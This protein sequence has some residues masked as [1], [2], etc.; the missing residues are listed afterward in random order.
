[1]LAIIQTQRLSNQ[2]YQRPEKQEGKFELP[3]LRS[4]ARL[5]LFASSTLTID[6][7]LVQTQMIIRDRQVTTTSLRY[8][9]MA[10]QTV[11]SMKN[12]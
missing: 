1:M 3:N 9:L 5:L 8:R 2:T 6:L 4:L 12:Q 10:W 11:K 7:N